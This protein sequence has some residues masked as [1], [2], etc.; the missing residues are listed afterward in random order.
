MPTQSETSDAAMLDL[1][2]RSGPLSVSEIADATEVTATAVRQRL[3][4]LMGQQLVQRKVQANRAE[5]NGRGRPGHHYSLTEKARRKS[6]NNFPDL[7]IVLWREIRA[8]SD[9]AVR[10]GLLARIAEMLAEKYRGQIT[11]DTLDER[12]ESLANLF[13]QRDV[14]VSTVAARACDNG[15]GAELPVLS[16]DDCPYPELAEEDRGICSV[17]KILFSQLLNE[18]VRLTQCRLDGHSCC[19]FSTS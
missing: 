16:V 10:R 15:A 11:G 5:R 13:A 7:A 19:Q 14:P 17:E 18:N 1:L 3:N 4:R 12:M 6:G 2:R 8:V 9:P